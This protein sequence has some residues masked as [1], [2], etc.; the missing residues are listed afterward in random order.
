MELLSVGVYIIMVFLTGIISMIR[1]GTKRK[2]IEAIAVTA[3]VGMFLISGVDKLLPPQVRTLLG[4][5]T[6]VWGGDDVF[7][8]S[9]IY[10]KTKNDILVAVVLIAGIIEVVGSLCVLYGH[11]N[12]DTTT[13]RNGLTVLSGFTAAA[14]LVVYANPWT[15]IK[16]IPVIS[17]INTLGGILA[18][19]S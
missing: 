10:T 1:K 12:R 7:R 4:G 11:Y 5:G 17:N 9:N 18:L 14:T 6:A 19:W 16:K 8:L 15:G 13:K 2:I 3:V